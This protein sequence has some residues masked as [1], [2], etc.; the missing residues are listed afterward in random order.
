VVKP[1]GEKRGPRSIPYQE[2]RKNGGGGVFFF[3]WGGWVCEKGGEGRESAMGSLSFRSDG[4]KGKE[5]EGRK[6]RTL[7][8][9]FIAHGKK[10]VE[11][12]E[13]GC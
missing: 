8:I 5:K 13:K 2:R 10:R 7:L 11:I 9:S 6:E 4:R 1:K 12:R 3:G